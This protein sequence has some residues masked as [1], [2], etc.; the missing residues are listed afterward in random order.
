MA[1]PSCNHEPMEL[2]RLL[3]QILRK[4]L[5]QGCLRSK[6]DGMA[7]FPILVPTQGSFEVWIAA[8]LLRLQPKN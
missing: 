3:F 4:S 8:Q 6:A 7:L 2:D 5:G 1:L